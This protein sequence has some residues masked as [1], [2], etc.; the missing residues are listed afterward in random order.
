LAADFGS[1][2]WGSGFGV[3]FGLEADVTFL[4]IAGLGLARLAGDFPTRPRLDGAAGA[5]FLDFAREFAGSA[6]RFS[7]ITCDPP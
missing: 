7:T 6:L 1:D 2:F 4:P 5:A 3:G